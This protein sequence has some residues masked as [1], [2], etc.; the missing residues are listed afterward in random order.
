MSLHCGLAEG[1]VLSGE[2]SGQSRETKMH[3]CVPVVSA[4]GSGE[5]RRKPK[6]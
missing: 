5:K 1:E 6:W 2:A 3:C 4:K